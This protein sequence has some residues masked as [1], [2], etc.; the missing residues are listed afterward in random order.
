[1]SDVS[2]PSRV[3]VAGI[4]NE[5][6]QD[7]GAGLAVARLVSS[8]SPE[9]GDVGPLGEPLDLL[10]RW[11]DADLA[12][13]IDTVRSGAQSGTIRLIELRESDDPTEEAVSG[14]TSTHGIG[15]IGVLRIARAINR[16]PHR[17]VVVA[18]EGSEFGLGVGLTPEVK[19]AVTDAAQQIIELLEEAA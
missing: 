8:S 13:V 11:D 16:A 7:D 10:G 14:A 18:I 2:H 1:V 9:I 5:Y 19:R 4:G 3:V 15:L 17:V 12:I 6:R